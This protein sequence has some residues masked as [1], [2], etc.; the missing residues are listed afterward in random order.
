MKRYQASSLARPLGGLAAGGAGADV[1]YG[2]VGD[3]GGDRD[4]NDWA[5]RQAA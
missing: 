1:I 3:D 4:D 5:W 2:G